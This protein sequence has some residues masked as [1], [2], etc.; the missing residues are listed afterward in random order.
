[1]YE[2]KKPAE[3]DVRFRESLK[4]GI[5]KAGLNAEQFERV[6]DVFLG[7]DEGGYVT[8]LSMNCW[9]GCECLKGRA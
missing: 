5:A 2:F 1:M 7:D 8:M 4:S 6:L 3:D 9:R